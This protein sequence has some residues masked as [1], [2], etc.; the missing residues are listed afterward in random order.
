MQLSFELSF[1]DVALSS[2]STK[3]PTSA[4]CKNHEQA[5]NSVS[6]SFLSEITFGQVREKAMKKVAYVNYNP[7]HR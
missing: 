5:A 4:D 2:T 6:L 3:S 7:T 1:V